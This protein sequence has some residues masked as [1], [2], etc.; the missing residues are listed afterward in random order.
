MCNN[1]RIETESN[2]ETNFSSKVFDETCLTENSSPPVN[3]KVQ[4]AFY[5]KSF[6]GH[7]FYNEKDVEDIVKLLESIMLINLYNKAKENNLKTE[8]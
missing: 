2:E 6:P 3:V 8:L 4:D 7:S 1:H 5:S